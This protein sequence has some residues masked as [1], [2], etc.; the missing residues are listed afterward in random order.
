LFAGALR[1]LPLLP[2]RG[3]VALAGALGN[4]A[5]LLARRD[6]RVAL[7]NLDLAFGSSLSRG[8]KRL[9][10]RQ[11]FRNF[12]QTVLDYFWFSRHR[13]ERIARWVV[14]DD[15]VAF[16]FGK[17]AL[18]AVTAHF[19]NWEILGQIAAIRGAPLHSVAKPVKNPA[20][21][22]RVNRLREESG[23]RIIPRDGALKTLVKVLRENGVVALL[24]D[25]DTREAEGGVFVDFFGV[26]APVSSAAA[27]LASKFRVPILPAFCRHEGGGRYRCYAREALLPEALQGLSAGEIT[28]RI[29]R[30]LESEIRSDPGQWLW[31]Y[32]RWKRRQ[33][34]V[35]AARY[36]FYADC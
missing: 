30:V 18:V 11:V 12:A 7:A 2:R 4:L 26:P 35:D 10:A 29:A 28:A 13:S 1:L 5:W 33:P 19:G 6:R 24:L 14:M 32:K 23:Q 8:Q 17:G 3:I 9:I 27:S 20:I 16:W 36:P 22:A 34:G 15:S 31:T 21:D 25:Q